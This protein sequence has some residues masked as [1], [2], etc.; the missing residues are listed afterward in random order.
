MPRGR[1][2]GTRNAPGH[3][4]GGK[5]K[6]SGR[7]RTTEKRKTTPDPETQ[8]RAKRQKTAHRLSEADT[9]REPGLSRSSARTTNIPSTSQTA[10]QKFYPM[11]RSSQMRATASSDAPEN[12]SVQ[13]GGHL[14]HISAII[15]P[16]ISASDSVSSGSLKLPPSELVRDPS[17]SF[18]GDRERPAEETPE[19]GLIFQAYLD[20]KLKEVMDQTTDNRPPDCNKKHT[21]WIRPPDSWFNLQADYDGHLSAPNSNPLNMD[22]RFGPVGT[23]TQLPVE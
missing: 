23:A 9:D 21:F 18:D 1:P 14:P 11:F 22:P 13:T 5:R 8:P 20:R 3:N 6:G 16:E 12:P 4:A 15:P 19:P 17:V 7:N 2:R 10:N